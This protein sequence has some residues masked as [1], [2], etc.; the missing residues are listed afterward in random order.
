MWGLR[1]RLKGFRAFSVGALIGSSWYPKPL[2]LNPDSGARS[3]VLVPK[4]SVS[5]SVS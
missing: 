1:F 4:T 2:T 5:A 3:D